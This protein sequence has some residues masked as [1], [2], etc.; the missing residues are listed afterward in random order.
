M[1]H[2]VSRY[3]LPFSKGEDALWFYLESPNIVEYLG[4][5]IPVH[6]EELSLKGAKPILIYA[7]TAITMGKLISQAPDCYPATR[8][9]HFGKGAHKGA[10]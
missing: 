7:N 2:N 6:P 5:S 9:G 1:W 8:R 10:S 3:K 4:L